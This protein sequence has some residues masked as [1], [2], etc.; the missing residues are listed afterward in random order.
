M[1]ILSAVSSSRCRSKPQNA[2]ALGDARAARPWWPK[3]RGLD[4]STLVLAHSPPIMGRKQATE[5]GGLIGI[6]RFAAIPAMPRK[7][8]CPLPCAKRFFHGK[9]FLSTSARSI[10]AR[11]CFVPLSRPASPAI[12][13]TAEVCPAPS[14]STATP[15]GDSRPGRLGMIAR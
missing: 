1:F 14:S 6:R 8:D 7:L 5:L 11:S 9:A 4:R 13:A 10:P 12:A 2:G 15:S 3:R